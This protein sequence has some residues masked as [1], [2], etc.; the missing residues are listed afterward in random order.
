VSLTDLA[1]AEGTPMISQV[2][3]GGTTAKWPQP[4]DRAQRL[5]FNLQ[6]LRL[7]AP[8]ISDDWH[9]SSRDQ[10]ACVFGV[11]QCAAA[12]KVDD[13]GQTCPDFLEHDV[14]ALVIRG[15]HVTPPSFVLSPGD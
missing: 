6:R 7:S 1:F 11:H 2:C 13:R 4:Y 10:L 3:R 5:K 8:N 14:D 9:G 15:R 12:D